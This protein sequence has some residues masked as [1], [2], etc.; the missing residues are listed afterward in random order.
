MVACSRVC[1][2]VSIVARFSLVAMPEIFLALVCAESRI[3]REGISGTLGCIVHVVERTGSR[4]QHGVIFVI[5]TAIV[6]RRVGQVGWNDA[7][8]TEGLV[9]VANDVGHRSTGVGT[10]A[11]TTT[12]TRQAALIVSC[13]GA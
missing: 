12:T 13:T 9:A 1:S 4:F 8:D 2:D 6:D 3:D 10:A 11:T 7:H 5:W